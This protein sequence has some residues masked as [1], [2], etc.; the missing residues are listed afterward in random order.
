MKK[1]GLGAMAAIL[2]LTTACEGRKD[3][4]RMEGMIWNTLYHITFEGPRELEDSVMP[5]LEEV[6]KSL[7][8]F[9]ENSLVSKLNAGDSIKADKHMLKVYAKSIE[10][11]RISKGNFDPTVSPLVT[12]WGF[13]PGHTATADTTTIDSILVYVG[14]NRTMLKDGQIIKADPRV[15]F[16]F[17]AIAK[18]YGCDAVGEMLKRNGV[19]NYMVEIGG[20]IAMSGKS[21]SGGKWQ[22]AID[23]PVED[24]GGTHE[25]ALVIAVTDAGMATSGN[26]RNFKEENGN[27]TA[28]TISPVTG[29]PFF[30]NILSATVVAPSCMDAD[31]LATACMASEEEDAKEILRKSGTEGLLIFADSVWMTPG[32]EK[33]VIS[34]ASEPGRK[35]RN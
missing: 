35:D 15:Q 20:E 6:G 11:N 22:I 34:K 30:S 4:Q 17:S 3:Y 24:K 8:V 29:R 32:F 7:S 19:N 5:V 2:M 25:T 26:Y 1:T 31:A 33:M 27:K 13:G 18:G 28:H 23:A 12:A 9:D 14:I 21:P 16:N 10:V